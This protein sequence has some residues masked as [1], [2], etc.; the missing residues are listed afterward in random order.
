MVKEI[1]LQH[2]Y[3]D[4]NLLGKF[5]DD[6]NYDLLVTEDCD[7]YKPS[8]FGDPRDEANVLLRFRKGYFSPELTG[9][10]YQGFRD[11]ATAS[12]NRGVAAGMITDAVQKQSPDATK[13]RGWV[14]EYHMAILNF[15]MQPSVISLFEDKKETLESVREKY[16]DSR[17]K[18]SG[19]RDPMAFGKMINS[20]RESMGDG[21]RGYIWLEEKIKANNFEFDRWADET[22]LK[23]KDNQAS[24]ARWV[25]DEFVSGTNYATPVFSGV[26]GYFD[27]Y[28]RIPYCRA[29]S[30]TANAVEKYQ[31]GVPFIEYLSD[32]FSKFLPNRYKN[33]LD[34]IMKIDQEFRIGKSVYTTLTINKNFRTA[35][36]TDSGDLTEGFGNLTCLS[37]K[38]WVGGFLCFPE[39][40]VAVDIR[41]GDMLL[42]DTHEFHGNTPISGIGDNPADRISIVAYFRENMLECSAKKYEDLR[43]EFIDHRKSNK[44]HKEWREHWNGVSPNMYTSDEWYDYIR[45]RYGDDFLKEYHPEAFEI[46]LDSFFEQG[47]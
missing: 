47:I 29:T 41:V 26:A 25:F 5:L 36:H 7:V 37:E 3:S 4:P 35:I 42:M 27:R 24:E 31:L 32:G 23:S 40:R 13:G 38:G 14:T 11:G 6:S 18:V 30:Y 46:S 1:F 2:K 17:N 44:Q 45:L 15:F 21:L 10:A 39:F 20:G 33:Q 8:S 12:H 43:S 9:P 19:A 28:P 34:S 22:A 16:K